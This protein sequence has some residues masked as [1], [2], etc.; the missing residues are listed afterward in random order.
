MCK[1]LRR[2]SIIAVVLAIVVACGLL[3]VYRMSR[4]EPSFYDRAVRIDTAELIGQPPY[5]VR[6]LLMA[7]WRRRGWPMQSMGYAQ[8]ESLAE[9]AIAGALGHGG[10]LSKQTLPGNILVECVDDGLWLRAVE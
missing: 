2:L 1:W 6:E 10:T 4:W 5:I 9:M 7:V 3:L 8:W